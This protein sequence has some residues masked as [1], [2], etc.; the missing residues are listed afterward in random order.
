METKHL[1]LFPAGNLDLGA[2]LFYQKGLL[3]NEKIIQEEKKGRKR[4]YA[5]A[6]NIHVITLFP[7][8]LYVGCNVQLLSRQSR[9]GTDDSLCCYHIHQH[10]CFRILYSDYAP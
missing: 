4:V 3:S 5:F 1:S 9:T 2:F 7:V 10:K 8:H 6:L